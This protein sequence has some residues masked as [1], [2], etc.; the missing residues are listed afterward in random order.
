MLPG[1]ASNVISDVRINF[2]EPKLSP[3]TWA[4]SNLFILP[5]FIDVHLCLPKPFFFKDY[6]PRPTTS[7]PSR[8]AERS[9]DALE[10]NANETV[11]RRTGP[12]RFLWLYH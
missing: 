2:R 4:Q 7:K 12:L 5:M 8:Q 9:P 11:E 10:K 6:F 3:V 1:N